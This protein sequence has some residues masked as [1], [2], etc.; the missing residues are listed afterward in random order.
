MVKQIRITYR[1]RHSY[2]TKS[3]QYR[4]VKTPGHRLV[5]QYRTKRV[6]GPRCGDCGAKLTGLPQI[7]PKDYRKLPKCKR[8]PAR[9]YGGTKCAKCVRTRIMRAFLVEEAKIVK[10]VLR[11]RGGTAKPAKK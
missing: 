7:R 5:I 8:A 11:A 6:K 1:R 10:S 2:N 3:N 4:K 9:A